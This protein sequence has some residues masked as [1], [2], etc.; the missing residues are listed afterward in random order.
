MSKGTFITFEGGEG[1]GK[2]TQVATLAQRLR[3]AGRSVVELREP[4][5][6]GLG[7]KIRSILLDP[8]SPAMCDEAEALLF[9]AS[10]AQLVHQ[11]IL[12]ALQKGHVVLSDRFV[13]SSLVYQ[14]VAR[15]LGVDA[16]L[17]A[18]QMALQGVWPDLT[19]YLDIE[20]SAGMKRARKRAIFDRI[21]LEE[22]KFHRDVRR[23][24]KALADQYPDRITVIDATPTED[25]VAAAVWDAVQA[26]F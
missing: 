8:N 13:D 16:V 22:M 3:D 6:T 5:G 10:R 26:V 20:A 11:V 9:A 15:G 14:G 2:T 25:Q 19:L 4:G 17:A 1:C 18:N 24:F 21:E 23:G 7:D 12:P